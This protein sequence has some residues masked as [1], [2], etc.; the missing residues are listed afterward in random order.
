[1]RSYC[2]I[3]LFLAN[4]ERSPNAKNFEPRFFRLIDHNRSDTVRAYYVHIGIRYAN[5]FH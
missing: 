3:A 5:G 1:M 2:I 4:E